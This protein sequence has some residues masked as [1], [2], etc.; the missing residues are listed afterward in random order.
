[1]KKLTL[2]VLV[3]SLV[4]STIGFGAMA[5]ADKPYAGTT[6][7]FWMQKYGGDPA[8]QPAAL[9]QLAAAF[10]EETGITVEYSIVDWSQANTKY[11]LAMTGG[12]CPDVADTFFA[13]SWVAI[14]GEERG[15]MNID[16]VVAELGG[17]DAFFDFAV[18]ECYVDGHWIGLPWR[19]DTRTAVYNTAMFEEAGITEF[20]KTYEELVEAAKKLTTYDANG[21]VDRAGFLFGQSE[22]RFDQTFFCILAGMGGSLMNE[23]FTEWTLDSQA[24]RDALQFMQ[25]CLHKENIMSDAILDPTHNALNTF[26]AGKAAIVLGVSP[27]AQSEVAANAPQIGEVTKNAVMPNKTGEGASSIA[28]AAPIVIFNTTEHPEACKEWLKFLFRT[29]NQ[30]ILDKGTD[31]VAVLGEVLKDEYFSSDWYQ[32]I[33]AQNDRAIPGDMPLS[34]WS[35]IDAFP[36]GPLN[37]MCTAVMAGE[38]VETALQTCLAEIESLMAELAE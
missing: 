19:G 21:N 9:D 36:N 22:A 32:T 28:F 3:L 1:M 6:I 7:T 33:L 25:D 18:P 20:P 27:A 24:T 26:Q 10:Y 8:T 31:Q 38:D 12:E 13:Y 16:D 4:F 37:T 29:E 23:D 17:E 14:G 2:F 11:T 35:Q 15:P 34:A 30:V 5:E